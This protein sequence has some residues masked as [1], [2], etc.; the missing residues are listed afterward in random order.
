M[1]DEEAQLPAEES[2]E[3]AP[4]WLVTFGDLMSLLL[5]FFVLLLSFSQ[6]DVAKFKELAGSLEKA[7]GVQR[8][9]PVYDL[10]KGMKMVARDFDQ[11]FVE[12]VMVG[13]PGPEQPSLEELATQL[14][15]LLA[16]LEAQGLVELDAQE[17]Y[18]VMRLLGHATFDSGKA[19]LRPDM[20]PILRAIGELISQTT[21][22][23]FV[24]GHTDNVPVRGG[25][26]KS[27]LALSAAR[28]AAVV[29]FFVSQGLLPPDKIA[30]MGF[31]EYRPVVPNDSPAHREKNRRVEIILASRPA[32]PG[33]APPLS[34]LTPLS[35]SP[36]APGK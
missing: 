8:K 6:T 25:V 23:V 36:L 26:Y 34:P 17:T 9:E 18:L 1:A 15:T 33:D 3:G 10:P 32:A 21:H 30:T 28:A 22:E 7:F 27:N 19:E 5:T 4:D 11:A 12:Q 16:P 13:N 24:A 2:E 29:D 31:G 20:V 14:H 35:I